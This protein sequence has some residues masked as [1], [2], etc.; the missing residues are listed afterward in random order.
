M[1]L[2]IL[3]VM[4]GEGVGTRVCADPWLLGRIVLKLVLVASTACYPWEELGNVVL[5]ALFDN[6]QELK[7]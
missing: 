4:A 7:F 1:A 2:R 5:S 3:K 6:A